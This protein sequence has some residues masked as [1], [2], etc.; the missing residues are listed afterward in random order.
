[1]AILPI[2]LQIQFSQLSNLGKMLSTGESIAQNQA[3]VAGEHVHNMTSVIDKSV[4][5]L[6]KT[7]EKENKIND[8]KKG[9]NPYKGSS[10]G[11]NKKD[12][13]NAEKENLEPFL[14]HIIDVRE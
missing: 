11:K 6:E 2:D 14:G 4:T 1:M 10:S 5:N 12:E 8:N 3:L 7:P 13:E 9:G